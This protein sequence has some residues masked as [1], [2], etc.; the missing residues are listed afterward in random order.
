M[1]IA[2]ILSEVDDLQSVRTLVLSPESSTLA[3]TRAEEKHVDSV[4]IVCVGEALLGV[5]NQAC[6]H[7]MERLTGIASGVRK[8]NLHLWV[9]DQEAVSALASAI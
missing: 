6:M 8:G 7:G 2:I 9:V 5:A 3:V 4:E 1:L